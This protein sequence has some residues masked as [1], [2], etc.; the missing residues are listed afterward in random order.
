M[1]Y[2]LPAGIIPPLGGTID[3]SPILAFITLDVRVSPAQFLPQ[4]VCVAKVAGLKWWHVY[5]LTV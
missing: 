1:Y 3:L 2:G 4:I 5:Q